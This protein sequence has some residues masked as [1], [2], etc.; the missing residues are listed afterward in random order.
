MET[1]NFTH[2]IKGT[3]DIYDKDNVIFSI[4]KRGK[5]KTLPYRLYRTMI[6]ENE[7][8]DM[9]YHALHHIMCHIKLPRIKSTGGYKI[10]WDYNKIIKRLKVIYNDLVVEEKTLI[11]DQ[12]L[13]FDDVLE[14]HSF[15]F[16]LPTFYS[17]I[18][19]YFPLYQC[20]NNDVL[21]HDLE[22]NLLLSEIIV[23]KSDRGIVDFHPNMIDNSPSEISKPKLECYYVNFTELE[24]QHIKLDNNKYIVN[25]SIETIF[26]RNKTQLESTILISK[27]VWHSTKDIINTSINI[28]GEYLIKKL[29]SSLTKVNRFH[30]YDFNLVNDTRKYRNSSLIKNGFLE[31]EMNLASLITL[32]CTETV[33]F[34]FK[35]NEK[36]NLTDLKI[37][38]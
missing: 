6:Q 36:T 4:H 11:V 7:K 14:E 29:D 13:K 31:F 33:E 1:Y 35:F 25:R 10:A 5:H 17:E 34:E 24:L 21:K 20:T 12:E 18:H 28:N 3:G 37:K 15:N 27:L 38:N 30:E 19:S 22:Y 16:K 26:N 2:K 9:S 23:V 8:I 32:Q